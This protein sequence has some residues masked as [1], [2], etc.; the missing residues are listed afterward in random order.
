V[1]V[2]QEAERRVIV[3]TLQEHIGQAL[4]ALA[5]NL[6]VLE[7]HSVDSRSADLICTMR[8]LTSG[9]LRELETLQHGL[10]PAA[11]DS[12]GIIPALE[13][14]IQE[15]AHATHIRVVLDAEVPPR[16][17]PP[18]VEITLFRIT[19]DALDHLRSQPCTGQIT[20]RLRVIKEYLYLVIENDGS[21]DVSRWNTSLMTARASALVGQ[22]ALMTLPYAGA[23]FD[24]ALPI[25][26]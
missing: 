11:L 20:V 21:N 4:T 18:D 24:I 7:Q 12:Q 14:Y 16:R 6:R 26:R 19:Q 13:V 9:A 3:H 8:K 1:L 17:F 22:C 15:F 25:N 5:L 23:R 2:S 10:Y